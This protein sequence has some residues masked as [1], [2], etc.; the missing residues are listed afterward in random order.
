MPISIL[1]PAQVI[2]FQACCTI[3]PFMTTLPPP[4]TLPQCQC[5]LD[6]YSD[7]LCPTI[8]PCNRD[9]MAITYGSPSLCPVTLNCEQTDYVRFQFADGAYINNIKVRNFRQLADI[10]CVNGQWRYYGH[11]VAYDKVLRHVVC[12]SVAI[13]V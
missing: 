5:P 4:T 13:P 2:I 11:Q 6:L 8:G 9:P 3:L 7:S 12:Y 10:Q 1:N